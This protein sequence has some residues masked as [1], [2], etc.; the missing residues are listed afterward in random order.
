M[1]M[2]KIGHGRLKFVYLDP[3]PVADPAFPRG[4][5]P[6]PQGGR[7]HTILP[8][9]SKNCMKLKEF[10]PPGGAHSLAPP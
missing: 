10:G 2:K 8:N 3:P 9:F 1:K 4:G 7:Q 6:T 5:A